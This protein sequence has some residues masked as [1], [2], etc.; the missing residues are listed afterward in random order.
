M[1]NGSPEIAADSLALPYCSDGEHL[2][3]KDLSRRPNPPLE[4]TVLASA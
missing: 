3:L 2:S 4:P 1:N